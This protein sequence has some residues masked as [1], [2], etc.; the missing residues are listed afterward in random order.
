LRG[1]WP[2]QTLTIGGHTYTR[3]QLVKI[4]QTPPKDGNAALILIHQLIAAELNIAAGASSAPVAATIAD[5]N[6]LLAANC[7][8]LFT[9]TCITNSTVSAQMIADS[10]ILDQYNNGLLGVPHC[11]TTLACPSHTRGHAPGH[12]P[13]KPAAPKKAPSKPIIPGK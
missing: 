9:T 12:P 1:V 11:S 5:A 7:G 6:A 4:L 8:N 13:K 3:E 10:S 2:V